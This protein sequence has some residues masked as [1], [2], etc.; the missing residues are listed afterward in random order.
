MTS[1]T[2]LRSIFGDLSEVVLPHIQ[3]EAVRIQRGRTA[4][5]TAHDAELPG[6]PLAD[7]LDPYQRAGVAAI[8]A[9]R[10]VILGHERGM[11]KSIQAIAALMVESTYPAVI[12]VPPS[13]TLN[14]I[15]EFSMWAP[16]VVTHR[17]T[18]T[19]IYDLPE[20]DVYIIGDSLLA[21]RPATKRFAGSP[22][23]TESLIDLDP[24]ALIIDEIQRFKNYK[25]KRTE[26][27][28]EISRYVDS[29]GLFVGLTGTLIKNRPDEVVPPL[30]IIGVMDPVF[31][32]MN[33]F[34][35]NYY[36]KVGEWGQRETTEEWM[37][38]VHEQMVDTFYA[39]L[40]FADVAYQLGDRAPQG[41]LRTPV[42]IEMTG[43]A[44]KDYKQA[45]DDLRSFLIDTRGERAAN[46]AMRA[47][48]I[49]RLGVLRRLAAL[50]K[51]E[52]TIKFV[53]D[54][55]DDGE[56]VIIF[57][58]HRDV[59]KAYAEEFDAPTIMGGMTVE[60]VEKAKEAFQS[61]E[62]PVIVLN[63][64][65][66]GTGHTLTAAANVVFA[67]YDWT[68]SGMEQCE[69]RADRRGQTRMVNSHWTMGVNG[70]S[71]I[72]EVLVDILNGKATIAGA[73]LDGIKGKVLLKQDIEDAL[74]DWA[75]NG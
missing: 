50:A 10:R 11:G 70:E 23:W 25:A 60:K 56:Q 1:R 42:A 14:W 38:E 21:P 22:G 47:E 12:V 65:A 74:I 4:I 40:T 75:E 68:P 39:R 44:A 43:K 15:K 49:V 34:Y 17:I 16:Q 45:R 6:H 57:A 7:V 73:M 5:N 59:V 9:E 36:P 66:G 37:L 2:A 32:G 35:D 24:R 20:A 72:D 63:I 3:G 55:V 62:K 69:G 28:K 67:E 29:S 31:G 54:L 26:C 18:G 64:E 52:N 51:M 48:A 13:L 58:V 33:T 30:E 46:R 71:T 27:V 61:G 19:D 41:V 53:R 8:L